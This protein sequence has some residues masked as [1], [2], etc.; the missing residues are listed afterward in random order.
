MQYYKITDNFILTK[1]HFQITL[2]NQHSVHWC[3]IFKVEFPVKQHI[4]KVIVS[5]KFSNFIKLNRKQTK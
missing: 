1:F 2:P 5:S 4:V 3:K